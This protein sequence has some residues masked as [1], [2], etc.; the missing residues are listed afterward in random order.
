MNMK[1]KCKDDYLRLIDK[2]EKEA[3]E[4]NGTYEFIGTTLKILGTTEFIEEVFDID[5]SFEYDFIKAI[6]TFERKNIGPY[7]T[8]KYFMIIPSIKEAIMQLLVD[9]VETRR[10]VINFPKEHCFQSVQFLIR[11]ETIHVVCHMRSCNV[12]KNLPHDILICSI[13]A[14]IFTS[15]LN[16]VINK[17]VYDYHSITISFGS[18]HVFKEEL[19]DVLWDA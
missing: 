10:C 4:V 15:L 9:C 11:E 8:S 14:D 1:I 7:D 2:I 5:D 3:N 16:N 18:L 19:S 17:E 13:M 12:I 6:S